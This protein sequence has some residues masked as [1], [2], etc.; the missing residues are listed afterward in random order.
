MAATFIFSLD[1]RVVEFEDM[2]AGKF[3]WGFVNLI[4]GLGKGSRR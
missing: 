3:Q 4:D 1:E 2:G